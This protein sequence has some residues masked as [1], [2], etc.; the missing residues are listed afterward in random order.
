MSKV[1][2]EDRQTL[3]P[4]VTTRGFRIVSLGRKY[5]DIFFLALRKKRG[6]YTRDLDKDYVLR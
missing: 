2:N 5:V 4:E 6:I 1:R 3:H